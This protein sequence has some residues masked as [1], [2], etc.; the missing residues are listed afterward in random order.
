MVSSAAFSLVSF[1]SIV[2]RSETRCAHGAEAVASSGDYNLRTRRPRAA[3]GIVCSA[4]PVDRLPV[5]RHGASQHFVFGEDAQDVLAF[6][7]W[8]GKQGYGS[9]SSMPAFTPEEFTE[10][11]RRIT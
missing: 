5:G 8:Y 1:V 6:S 2:L 7:A 10:A 11:L 4:G 9:I 3:Q